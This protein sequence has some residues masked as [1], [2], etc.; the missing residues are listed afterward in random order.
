MRWVGGEVELGG[1]DSLGVDRVERGRGVGV[2]A[3]ILGIPFIYRK[4]VDEPFPNDAYHRLI[5]GR[6]CQTWIVASNATR[7][8]L[9]DSAPWLD[10]NRVHV[11]PNGIDLENALDAPHAEIPTS[12][13]GCTFGFVGRFEERKGVFDLAE[14]WRRVVNDR[15][16]DRLVLVGWGDGESRLRQMLDGMDSVSWLGRRDDAAARRPV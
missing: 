3:R 1:V 5:Y 4:E 11:I 6:I 7:T 15:P 12:E 13:T 10:A 16:N 8:T 9:L 2:A 14:A